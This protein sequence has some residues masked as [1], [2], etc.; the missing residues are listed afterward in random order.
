M[1]KKT[2][3]IILIIISLF[4]IMGSIKTLL[5]TNEETANKYKKSLEA[6]GVTLSNDEVYK[7]LEGTY[8]ATRV[9]S[10]VFIILFTWVGY[11]GYKMCK[12]KPVD[13]IKE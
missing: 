3:G 8:T 4:F 1:R 12:K 6:K 13:I 2:I 7:L 11:K 5:T 9:S 10:V